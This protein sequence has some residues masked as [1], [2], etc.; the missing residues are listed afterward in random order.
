MA[1]LNQSPRKP[2]P[3]SNKLEQLKVR[4]LQILDP[5][6][7]DDKA[8]KLCSIF[9][10][11]L[12]IASITA[13]ILESV[14][15]YHEK[16]GWLFNNFEFYCI[17]VFTVEYVLRVWSS[18]SRYAKSQGGSWRGRKEY[19]FS[20]FGLVDLL[21]TLP[22][23]L[24]VFFP[25]ADLRAIRVVRMLR[26]FKLS[27]YNSALEDLYSAVRDERQSFIAALYILAIA[28]VVTSSLM[29]Y[30]EHDA[31]PDKFSSIPAA[32]WW[33]IISL[34]TVGYGDVYPITP[35]GQII[36]TLTA[37][38]GV[39]T[40]AMLTGIVAAAF[41]NQMERRKTLFES[42]LRGVLSDGVITSDEKGSL[43]KLQ[44]QFNL[45]DDVVEALTKAV[46]SEIPKK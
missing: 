45:S 20:F 13:V 39:C 14:P 25:G 2:N 21:A 19:I 26:I 23:Y 1:S 12:I 22:Y 16:Y 4:V 8:S 40:V 18:G 31:Q 17:I 28:I 3:D 32:M 35:L 43:E 33:A 11:T 42:E 30:A 36:G 10:A 7:K 27:H 46:K 29:Y 6:L 5:P 24:Q 15:A 44:K 34:T 41:A 38:V 37:F 9:I